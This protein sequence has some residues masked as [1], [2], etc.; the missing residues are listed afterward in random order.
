MKR[1]IILFGPLL[2][3]FELSAQSV[4]QG[5]QQMYY[6]R[7]KTTQKDYAEAID[8]FEKLLQV[9][10]ENANAKKYIEMLENNLT[11]KGSK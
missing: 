8:Y 2:G 9:E 6:E 3:A 7:Y 5:V 1:I 11:E 10:P 4:E